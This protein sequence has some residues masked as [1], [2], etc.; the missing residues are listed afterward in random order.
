LTSA[1][2]GEHSPRTGLELTCLGNTLRARC[3]F[4]EAMQAYRAAGHALRRSVPPQHE[5]VTYLLYAAS[6]PWVD[7]DPAAAT[8]LQVS[9]A[10]RLAG[11]IYGEPLAEAVAL[12]GLAADLVDD[13]FH[14]EAEAM[15]LH[16]ERELQTRLGPRNV[17][18]A[19]VKA[20]LAH[21]YAVAG[22]WRKAR[23]CLNG[24]LALRRHHEQTGSPAWLTCLE[25]LH[26]VA[27]CS[28]R[29]M[30]GWQLARLVE[31]SAQVRGED[32]ARTVELTLLRAE[33]LLAGGATE[34][35]G[36]LLRGLREALQEEGPADGA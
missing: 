33:Q 4:D 35:A 32:D 20:R 27:A 23:A 6:V 19:D 7:C 18:V 26:A 13:G 16:V 12:L 2:H 36:R 28:G 17:L 11:E 31:A 15:Y 30:P 9:R 25:T 21:L 24:E 10:S 14:E 8:A 34:R 1:A 3:K 5:H 22:H 29:P